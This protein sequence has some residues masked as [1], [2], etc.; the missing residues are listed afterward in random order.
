M[1]GFNHTHL[2]RHSFASHM[3]SVRLSSSDCVHDIKSSDRTFYATTKFLQTLLE[4]TVQGKVAYL[5][6]DIEE[7]RRCPSFLHFSTGPE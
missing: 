1:I 7:L 4:R 5:D 3:S 6:H 2:M